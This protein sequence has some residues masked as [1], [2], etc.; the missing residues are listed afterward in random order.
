MKKKIIFF[1]LISLIFIAES[2]SEKPILFVGATTHVGNGNVIA[3]SIVSIHNGKFE[4]IG[5]TAPIIANNK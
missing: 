5:N 4:I 1:L 3:N 2:K